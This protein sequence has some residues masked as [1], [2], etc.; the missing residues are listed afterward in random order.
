MTPERVELLNSIGFIWNSH[1]SSFGK[2]LDDLQEYIALHGHPNVPSQYP[3]NQ[4]LSTWVKCQRR[5]YKLL[6][7]GQKSNITR[8]RINILNQLNFV[9]EV[10]STHK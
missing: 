5:Q 4:K 1:L 6:M 3:A 2:R 7:T 10:R 9:W 8:E